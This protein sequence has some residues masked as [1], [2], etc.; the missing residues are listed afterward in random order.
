MKITTVPGLVIILFI[1]FILPASGGCSTDQSSGKAATGLDTPVGMVDGEYITV[2]DLLNHP[3][4]Q[5]IVDDLIYAKL[6]EAKAKEKGFVA[7]DDMV[8]DAMKPYIDKEGGRAAFL[9]LQH[10]KGLTLEK[11]IEFGKIGLLQEDI[12]NELLVEPTY[13]EVVDFLN[14]DAGK[15]LYNLKAQDLGKSVDEVTVE[16]V[17]DDAF[18]R[19]LEVRRRDLYDKLRDEILPK[20]HQVANLLKAAVLDDKPGEAWVAEEPSTPLPPAGELPGATGEEETSPGTEP[21][22]GP[23]ETPEGETGGE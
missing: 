5:T 3:D 23:V 18:N 22:V 8:F 20:G 4:C 17:Y 7:T 1:L 2:S 16:D 12:V 21:E 11:T 6:I 9:D 19:L 15:F 13:D 10:S 14:T